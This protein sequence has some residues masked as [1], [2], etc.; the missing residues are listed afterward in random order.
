MR[1]SARNR[2]HQLTRS[3]PATYGSQPASYCPRRRRAAATSMGEVTEALARHNLSAYAAAFDAE[4]YEFLSDL[5]LSSSDHHQGEWRELAKLIKL[6]T[7]HQKRFAAF[8]QS[9]CTGDGDERVTAWPPRDTATSFKVALSPRA[10]AIYHGDASAAEK[11]TL[12]A[13]PRKQSRTNPFRNK[14]PSATGNAE[15]RHARIR[16]QRRG[17]ATSA[18]ES[19]AERVRA[20]AAQIPKWESARQTTDERVAGMTHKIAEWAACSRKRDEMEKSARRE[21]EAEES[22]R[23]KRLKRFGEQAP[24]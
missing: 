3:H 10:S 5:P 11:E 16:R 1:A 21:Q 19:T 6:K 13:A 7:G 12:G 24:H 18:A 14:K 15:D 2:R 17:S 4:G 8:V 23:A 20:M 22:R 9:C